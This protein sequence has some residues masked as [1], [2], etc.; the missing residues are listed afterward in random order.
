MR[1]RK[2]RR[3]R[4]IMIHARTDRMSKIVVLL[5]FAVMMAML[6]VGCGKKAE[7]PQAAGDTAGGGIATA[8]SALSTLAPDAKLLLVQTAMSTPATGTPVWAYLFGS[9]KDDKTYVVYVSEGAVMSAGEYGAAGLPA[10][11]WAKVP[12]TTSFKVD[13]DAALT[14]AM[15]AAGIKEKPGFSMGMTTYIPSAEATAA[16]TAFTWYVSLE[17]GASG[18]TTATVQVDVNTGKA[19]VDK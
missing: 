16:G 5:V 14:K 12:T 19:K 10:E 7:T 2:T 3:K 13:S 6:I 9:P 8:Q 15:E 11:E 17:P 1:M 18:G 4:A